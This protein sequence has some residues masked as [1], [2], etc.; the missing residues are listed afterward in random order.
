MQRTPTA[1][2]VLDVGCWS[3][4]AGRFLAASRSAVVD[5][6]EPDAAMAARAAADY[7]DV[8]VKPVE[9][10][11]GELAA[12][13]RSYDVVLFLDVLEHLVCPEGVIEATRPLVRPGGRLLVSIPN[14]AHWSLRKEL[15]LG[16]WRYT[17]S[18]LMDRTHLRFYTRETARAL[19][20]AGAGWRIAYEDATFDRL[21]L[22][23]L[24]DRFLE[25]L[26]RW[27]GPLAVQFLFDVALVRA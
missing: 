27:P 1:S 5:G 13:G 26:R 22:V 19:L 2:R 21:P 16:R 15:L 10:A 18:G 25:R 9:V 7:R 23:D 20:T 3:G 14:V 24:P 12:E 17:D 6:V 8:V 4:F 11:L